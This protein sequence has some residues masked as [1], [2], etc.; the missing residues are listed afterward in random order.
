MQTAPTH[1]PTEHF[2][3]LS[4]SSPV[5]DETSDAAQVQLAAQAADGDSDALTQLYE[6]HK[7]RVFAVAYRVLRDA[8]EAADILQDTF[9]VLLEGRRGRP[10][11]TSVRGWL[12]RVASNLAIDRYRQ[13]RVRSAKPGDRPA[14]F[15]RSAPERAP[16]AAA[17]GGELSVEVQDAVDQLSDKL[18]G[19]IVLRYGAG[20][21]YEEVAAALD[22]S[23]GTV[24]SRLAR[25][26]ARLTGA[27][28]HLREHVE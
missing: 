17:M 8:A 21:S 25:A 28:E 1:D 22:C 16:D 5:S 9:I 15:E 6:A 12:V 2:D 27:L 19:V 18:R 20:L 11:Q 14:E 24:K 23:I 13:R 3:P 7:D 10:P 26:H 4:A